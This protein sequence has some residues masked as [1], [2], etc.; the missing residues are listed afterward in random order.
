MMRLGAKFILA[1]TK[2]FPVKGVHPLDLEE[3]GLGS[4]P[5]WEY[6]IAVKT[7]K[8]FPKEYTSKEFLS[9]KTVLDDC[10]GSGGKALL[11]SE[12]GASKVIGIDIGSK[13]IEEANNFAKSKGNA[14][15]EFK[16]GDAHSLPFADKSFDLVY[17]FDAFEHVS[18]PDKMLSEAKRVLKPGGKLIMSFTTWGKAKGHHLT[19][20]INVPW[21]HLLVSE[22]SLMEAYKAKAKPERYIFRAGSP[23]SKKLAYCNKMNLRWAKK[24]VKNSGMKV[25]LFKPVSYPGLLGIMTKIGLAEYFSRV[26]TAVLEA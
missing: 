21:A 5:Q 22:G 2:V 25:L 7:M 1:L 26:V 24:L 20:A 9:G 14:N 12:L 17:S 10:C 18:M 8:Y 6:D 15:V 16:V 13:F 11:L 4:Y 3:K 19:D 23:D